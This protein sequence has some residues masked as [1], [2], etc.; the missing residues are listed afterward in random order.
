LIATHPPYANIIS[1]SNKRN[2]VTGDLSFAHSLI[3]YLG[4]I[5]E[6]AKESYRVL[7]PGRFCAILIGDT[8]KHRHQVPISF[9]V[10]QTFLKA[11]FI[12]R[13]DIMKCQWKTKATRERWMGLS[14]VAQEQ[15][16]DIDR[17]GKNAYYTDFLLLAYEHLFIFRKPEEGED[18]SELKSSKLTM[19]EQIMQ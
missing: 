9:G 13:E 11:G 2:R 19:C 5:S 1:Y 14:K 3:D 7:R 8:R 10:L 6:I 15:W 16:V 17:K 12:L 4:G 18:I